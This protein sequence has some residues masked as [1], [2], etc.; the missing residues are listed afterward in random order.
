MLAC[1][2][3]I[4]IQ[5]PSKIIVAVPVTTLAAGHQVIG[6]VDDFICIVK[7]FDFQRTDDF[8]ENLPRVCDE[9]VKNFLD[10]V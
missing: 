10:L 8:Y 3:S 2:K 5:K 7:T 4:K 9:E 1:L 6:E